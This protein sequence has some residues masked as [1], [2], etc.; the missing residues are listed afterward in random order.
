[1]MTG[2][3]TPTDQKSKPSPRGTVLQVSHLS[4]RYGGVEA[5]QDV[6][7]SVPA[8]MV[9]CVLGPNGA[10]KSTLGNCIAGNIRTA[11]GTILVGDSD[12]S[13]LPAHVRARRGIA[14]MPEGGDTFPALTVAENL[15][16]GV[17]TARARAGQQ[18]LERAAAL[19][20]FIGQRARTQAGMLSGGEQQ[21][22]SLARILIEEPSLIVID[23]L[24]HGLAPAIVEGLFATLGAQKGSTTFILIEQYLH[25]AFEVADDVLVLSRGQARF[26]GSA[27]ETTV[28]Q[29]EDLYLADT[30]PA[31][32][33]PISG[34]S[35]NDKEDNH[36]TVEPERWISRVRAAQAGQAPGHREM[37]SAWASFLQA[38]SGG[39]LDRMR[40][41]LAPD[42]FVRSW[43]ADRRLPPAGYLEGA[44]QIVAAWGELC[45]PGHVPPEELEVERLLV[46]DDGLAMDGTYRVVHPAAAVPAL[47]TE[48]AG[49][50]LVSVRAAILVRFSGALIAGY[51]I[52][53]DIH[54]TVTPQPAPAEHLVQEVR[55]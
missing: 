34:T 12:V 47:V 44:D 29:V 16:V 7:F 2:R 28:G 50:V 15:M 45:A 23:E 49:D 19:F 11:P 10:G 3:L 54:Y 51:D 14:Y 21:M 27:T 43:G 41:L 35:P 39:D 32:E 9:L 30:A 5:V 52:Y 40:W 25:R 46:S 6:S 38:K 37:L 18:R 26:L 13:Q 4:H 55:Q 17:G 24:S 8:G 36:M 53:W 22:L 48:G 33:P 1:M 42:A 31:Q 20:P